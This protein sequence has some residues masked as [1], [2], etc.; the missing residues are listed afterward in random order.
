MGRS[1]SYAE[2][3]WERNCNLGCDE[4]VKSSRTAH[5]ELCYLLRGGRGCCGN[6]HCMV[7]GMSFSCNELSQKVGSQP[8]LV[9]RMTWLVAQMR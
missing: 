2:V 9:Q 3:K 4:T 6:K 5:Y 1:V 7:E 8:W